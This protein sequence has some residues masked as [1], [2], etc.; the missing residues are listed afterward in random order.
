MIENGTW[1][2]RTHR[3]L[4]SV[5]EEELKSAGAKYLYVSDGNIKFKADEKELYHFL[6][7]TF[8][9]TSVE[10]LLSQPMDIREA[11]I[12]TL[13]NAVPWQDVIPLESVFKVQALNNG[14]HKSGLRNLATELEKSISSFFKK[15][16]GSA[17]K[18]ATAEE[19]P[20]FVVLLHV[21]NNGSCYLALEAGGEPFASRAVANST[22]GGMLSPALAAGLILMSGWDKTSVFIDPF[23]GDGTFVL[24]AARIAKNRTPAF[25]NDDFLMKRWRTFRHALWKK[26]REALLPEIRKDVNWIN[27]IESRRFIFNVLQT[28]VR[29]NRLTE[30]INLKIGNAHDIF[31]PSAP[32]VIMAAP[33]AK[34][35][36]EILDKFVKHVKKFA[37]GYTLSL[38]TP[39]NNLDSL[40]NMKP[41][42]VLKIDYDEREYSFMQFEI[43]KPVRKEFPPKQ[44]DEKKGRYKR[45]GK[46]ERKPYKSVGADRKHQVGRFK[47]KGERTE[48]PKRD[49]KPSGKRGRA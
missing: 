32:G 15:Q 14:T 44:G 41:D 11:D 8:V 46:P 24:E 31:I 42:R 10:V 22:E 37:G 23:A 9:C 4:E 36:A 39:L 38:F 17:P 2:A 30:N 27:A 34:A 25:E 21:E 40:L 5:L 28:S 29:K 18:V 20:E 48:R 13:T 7:N 3:G 47:G 35:D 33:H 16:F 1:Q 6:L 19:E 45:D 49:G 26:T 12:T 43:F